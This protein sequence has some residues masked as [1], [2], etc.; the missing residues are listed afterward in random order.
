[1]ES[2]LVIAHNIKVVSWDEGLYCWPLR[3]GRA[4]EVADNVV[5]QVMHRGNGAWAMG[6]QTIFRKAVMLKAHSMQQA[7]AL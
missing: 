3:K 4:V 7:G 2:V 5:A 6:W 1:M